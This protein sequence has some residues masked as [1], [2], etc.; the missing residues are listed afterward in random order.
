MIR[1]KQKKPQQN[2]SP[3]ERFSLLFSEYPTVYLRQLGQIKW[4]DR[5][6]I[7]VCTLTFVID[8]LVCVT[9]KRFHSVLHRTL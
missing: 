8:C 5:N 6:I 7:L 2:F 3:G 4:H 1:E 9:K